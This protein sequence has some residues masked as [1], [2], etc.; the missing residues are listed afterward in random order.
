MTN[1]FNP[2]FDFLAFALNISRPALDDRFIEKAFI[3][4]ILLEIS[5]ENFNNIITPVK[6]GTLTRGNRRID[7]KKGKRRFSKN[8]LFFIYLN[9]II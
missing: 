9:S 7:S 8:Y 5:L 3:K 4:I 1:D 6:V 2:K